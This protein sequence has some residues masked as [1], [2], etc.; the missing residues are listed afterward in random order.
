[1]KVL[2]VVPAR[3]GSKGVP[4]KNVRP[5]VGRPLLAYTSDCIR[6][7][8]RIT[9]AL[10]SSDDAEILAV[11]RQLGLEAPF[12]RPASL[13]GDHVPSADVA[14]HALGH[15]E[16]EEGEVYDAVVLLEPTAPLR[17]AEDIDAALD[18]L[19]A[20][21]AD[22]VVSVCRVEAPH[23]GKMQVIEGGVLKPFMPDIWRDGIPRQKLFPVYFLNGAVYAVRREILQRTGSLWGAR[24]LAYVMPPER[25]VN[26]DAALDFRIA[27][28]LLT[29]SHEKMGEDRALPN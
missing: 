2:A 17:T 7:S 23:P 5:L 4:G 11:G 3:G 28:A 27:E 1:M 12:V 18:A 22:S 15:V 8:R 10:L 16:Q 29:Q 25:S 20:S 9:R 24:T 6:A 14:L 21:D 26:I 13:A 19:L